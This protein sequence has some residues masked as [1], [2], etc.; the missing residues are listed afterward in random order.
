MKEPYQKYLDALRQ[1]GAPDTVIQYWQ[2]AF[3]TKGRAKLAKV[4][5]VIPHKMAQIETFCREI[6]SNLNHVIDN[7]N[8]DPDDFDENIPFAGK[9]LGVINMA[10]GE[11]PIKVCHNGMVRHYIASED[12]ILGADEVVEVTVF[13]SAMIDL[14]VFDDFDSQ[15]EYGINPDHITPY[16]VEIQHETDC[17]KVLFYFADIYE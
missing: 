15:L 2:Q 7:I 16:K 10:A 6:D 4:P 11:P 1:A 3:E 13:S 5:K 17:S 9:W 12:N 14:E 8:P